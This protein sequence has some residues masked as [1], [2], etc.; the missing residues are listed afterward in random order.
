[1]RRLSGR[2]GGL[3]RG[4]RGV[5]QALPADGQNRGRLESKGWRREFTLR[6]HIYPR[7]PLPSHRPLRRWR[8]SS[9][10]GKGPGSGVRDMRDRLGN[11]LAHKSRSSRPGAYNTLPAIALGQ[12]PLASDIRR[13]RSCD[14]GSRAV[15]HRPQQCPALVILPFFL[16]WRSAAFIFNPFRARQFQCIVLFAVPHL[17]PA[18]R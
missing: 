4:D 10:A 6:L 2:R 11:A 14:C 17:F 12:G 18:L 1:M 5:E 8:A 13:N 9:R 16:L 15:Q 3:S 7:Q